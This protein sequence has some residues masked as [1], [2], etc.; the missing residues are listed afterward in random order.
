V[1]VEQDACLNIA[2]QPPC[3]NVYR[4]VAGSADVMTLAREHVEEN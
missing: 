4:D 3:M 1:L 2:Q